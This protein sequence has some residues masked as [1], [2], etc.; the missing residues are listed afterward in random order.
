L[1][2]LTS[3]LDRE[4]NDLA[5]HP[6]FVRFIGEATRYLTGATQTP[7]A[8]VGTL[9]PTAVSGRTGAQVFDPKGQRVLPLSDTAGATR[10]I[11]EQTGFYEVRGGGRSD[12][13]AANVDPRESDLTPLSQESIERWQRLQSN[14]AAAQDQAATAT[15]QAESAPQMKSI[16]PWILLLAVTLAFVEPVVANSYLHVRRGVPT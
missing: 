6:L 7:I 2:V 3:P 13:V 8:T 11:A 10:L 5:I 16:W 9:L 15:A 14:A 1:L 4:W 12:W